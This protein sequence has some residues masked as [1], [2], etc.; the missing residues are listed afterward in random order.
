MNFAE[1]EREECNM[2]TLEELRKRMAKKV[3]RG[4]L[5]KEAFEKAFAHT[6]MFGVYRGMSA[7]RYHEINGIKR[8]E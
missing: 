4:E 2:K 1:K 3:K 7:A 5:E 8:G 6:S